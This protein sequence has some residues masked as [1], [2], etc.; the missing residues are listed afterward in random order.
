MRKIYD[1][2]FRKQTGAGTG[3]DWQGRLSVLAGTTEK[4]YPS[5][6]MF[7]AMGERFL[8]W[9]L[10]QPNDREV[11]KLA[12]QNLDD[13]PATAQMTAAFAEFLNN[14]PLPVDIKRVD[15]KTENQ[16]VDLAVFVCKA[17]TPVE[18]RKYHRDS[19]IEQVYRP[20]Q[21][22]RF[23]KQILGFGLGLQA[24]S[25]GALTDDDR[26][27]LCKM[28]LDSIPSIRRKCLQ[29]LTQYNEVEIGRA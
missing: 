20:E 29:A 15:E 26:H 3:T 13:G 22:P 2:D 17:R 11:A 24:L 12:A 8:M 7:G 1:G 21:P 4:I 16:I 28:A 5:M 23:V 19:P 27:I 10:D 25:G 6:G 18:R 9:D 14:F